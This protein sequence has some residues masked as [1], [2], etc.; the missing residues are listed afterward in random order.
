VSIAEFLVA[1]SLNALCAA[2]V[3]DLTPCDLAML[4]SKSGRDPKYLKT[5]YQGV[6]T[7]DQIR[8]ING[9][10]NSSKRLK[11]ASFSRVDSW[12]KTILYSPQGR[13][14]GWW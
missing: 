11:N 5:K 12:E 13:N 4:V 3:A 6:S 8:E 7:L 2:L 9:F 14:G 10:L 1:G